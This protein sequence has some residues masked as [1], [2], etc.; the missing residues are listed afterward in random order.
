MRGVTCTG[1]TPNPSSAYRNGVRAVEAAAIP[2]V[3][4]ADTTATLGK[5]IKA[6]RDAP[7]KWEAALGGDRKDGVAAVVEM[8]DLLWKGQHDRHGFVEDDRPLEV[9]Q[10]EAE[11]A[12]ALA[13]TLVQL[14][15]NGGVRRRE[16][17]S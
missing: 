8:M 3:L 13:V 5:M 16:R 12:V 9:S 2:V 14:L 1:E 15:T 11:F 4:P 7:S 6:M 10:E 17:P